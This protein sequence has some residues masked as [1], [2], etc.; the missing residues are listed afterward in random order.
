MGPKS[1]QAEICPIT[2][3]KLNYM[4]E[5]CEEEED[6]NSTFVYIAM[7]LSVL[8]LFSHPHVF[9]LLGLEMLFV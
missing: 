8:L 4:D 9:T 6:I 3:C 2:H 5:L 7:T 1:L